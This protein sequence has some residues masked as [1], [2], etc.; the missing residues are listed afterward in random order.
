MVI[1]AGN[2][3]VY[4]DSAIPLRVKRSMDIPQSVVTGFTP[5]TTGLET[6]YQ[7]DYLLHINSFDI[8]PSPKVGLVLTE[9]KI[10]D[11]SEE[12]RVR[13]VKVSPHG[14]AGEAG[15]KEKDIILTVNDQKIA[16][17]NDLKIILMDKRPGDTVMMKVL[18]EN[19]FFTDKELDFEVE[20]SSLMGMRGGR[21]PNHP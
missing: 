6:G 1:I 14:K 15:I 18:R 19:V 8:E 3:H 20:L 2:G 13:V 7:V 9:E 11:D 10:S 5:E 12:T 4:K 17:I 21:P 16:D